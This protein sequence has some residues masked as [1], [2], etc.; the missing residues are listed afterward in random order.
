MKRNPASHM[1]SVDPILR[2][3]Y[4]VKATLNRKAKFDLKVL[5]AQVRKEAQQRKDARSKAA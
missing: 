4:A 3:L 2:E 1:R 5:C